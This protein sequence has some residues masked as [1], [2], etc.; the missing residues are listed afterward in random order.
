MP[1]LPTWTREALTPR[2]RLARQFVSRPWSQDAERSLEGLAQRV[3]CAREGERNKLL[4]WAAYK[5]GEL[6]REG[7]INEHLAKERLT[8]AGLSAGLPL[9]EVMRTVRSGLE[10]GPH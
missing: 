6:V 10:A 9:A 5:A 4:N 8:H 1:P 7:K 2:T 3:E